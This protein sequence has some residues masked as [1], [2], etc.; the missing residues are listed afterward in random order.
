MNLTRIIAAALTAGAA[1]TTMP[2]PAQAA[3]NGEAI[4]ALNSLTVRGKAPMTGYSRAQFPHWKDI[5]GDGCDAR[6]QVL[7]KDMHGEIVKPRCKVVFGVLKDPYTGKM[8]VWKKGSNK[9]DI[10]HAVSLGNAW[11]SGAWNPRAGWTKAK[12]TQIANDPLNL[13]AVS[14]SANRAKSDKDAS[15]WQPSNK[16]YRCALAARQVAVKAKYNLSVTPAEK[17]ALMTNLRPGC[18]LPRR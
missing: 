17:S 4:R 7:I 18:A 9:V 15:A 5:E 10:D 11:V 1:L 16:S 3:P 8:V 6:N 14:A 2:V 12:R 13:L